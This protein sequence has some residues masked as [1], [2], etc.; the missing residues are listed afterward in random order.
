MTELKEA[1]EWFENAHLRHS[2]LRLDLWLAEGH[3]FR[4]D[5]AS[6]RPLIEEVLREGPAKREGEGQMPRGHG[7][8]NSA[9]SR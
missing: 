8:W 1:A 7:R 5:R 4:G 6:A 3:L 9:I 2:H